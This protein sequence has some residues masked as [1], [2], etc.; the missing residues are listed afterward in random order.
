MTEATGTTS[1]N[2]ATPGAGALLRAA[3]ERQG[4]HIAALAAAIKVSPRKLDALENDRWNELPDATFTRALAQTVCRTLKI[5]AKPVLDLLPQA[6]AV[7]LAPSA[8]A[9]NEPFRARSTRDDGGWAALA[10]RPM[11][12]AALLLLLAAAIVYLAPTIGWPPEREAT[13]VVAPAASSASPASPA[14]AGAATQEAAPATTSAASAVVAVPD[15]VASAPAVVPAPG[16]APAASAATPVVAMPVPAP[17]AAPAAAAALS[18]SAPTTALAT[19]PALLRLRTR[20]PSWVEVRDSSGRVLLSR[21]LTAGESVGIDGQAPLRLVV[22]NASATEVLLRGRPVD[23]TPH[24]RD[25]VAR[26]ELQ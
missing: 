3:R 7:T 12:I 14:S 19:A 5:D 18:A 9:L 16:V 24:S 2:S 26:L 1:A 4:L 21:L 23:L 22:G 20:A 17:K 15:S 25:S 11:V 6:E 10:V 8:G 13:P